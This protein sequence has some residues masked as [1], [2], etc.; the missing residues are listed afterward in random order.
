MDEAAER[1]IE[2]TAERIK[3]ISDETVASASL[4]LA[5]QILISWP[6]NPEEA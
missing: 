3:E 1:V 6:S 5:S 4:A 2:E